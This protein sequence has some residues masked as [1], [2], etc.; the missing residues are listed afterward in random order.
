MQEI[1]GNLW[2]VEAD[3]RLIT[4]NGEITKSGKV[5]MGR[6]CAKEARDGVPGID[7]RLAGLVAKHGNR[8]MRC[9]RVNGADLATFPVKHK[10][11]ESADLDLIRQSAVQL[12][13]LTDRFGYQNVVLPRPGCGNGRRKWADVAPILKEVLDDRFSVVTH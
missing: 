13:T 4:T 7:I 1:R 2:A 8:V 5:V 9:A 11:R 10:W 12:V 3:L 6:G